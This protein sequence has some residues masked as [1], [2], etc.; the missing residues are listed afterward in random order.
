M[1]SPR[2]RSR[3][4]ARAV[5]KMIGIAARPLVVEQLLGDLPAVEPR[6]H[7]VEQDHVGQLARAPR[8][9][10]SA[11]RPPRAPPS[12]PPRGS[13][14]RAAGSA[15]RRRSRSTRV[16]TLIR[17]PC[18]FEPRFTS[19]RS[20]RGRQLE[21]RSSTPRPRRESTQI[22]PP[23]A[24]T[25]PLRDEEPEPGAAGGRARRLGAVELREDP[26]AA[27]PSGMPI[28]LVGDAA[29]RPRRRAARAATVTVPPSGEYLTALSTRLVEDLAQLVAVGL[30]VERLLAAG[31]ATNWC[32]FARRAPARSRPTSLDDARA[33]RSAR[34]APAG[35]RVS[36]RATLSSWSTIAVRRSDSEAM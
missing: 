17:I 3:N 32:P 6:H 21:R 12:P 13:R 26:L 31:R 8:R 5:R 29:P 11:R 20:P 25:S 35:R 33:R 7:H 14:G 34:A 27:R 18:P 30:R 23:I 9:A 22:R 24:A 10:R 4:S 15:P 2:A 28:A 36:S 16:V 1:S 19:S